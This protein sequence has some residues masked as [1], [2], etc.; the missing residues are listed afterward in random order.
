MAA[1]QEGVGLDRERAVRRE[2]AEDAGPEE[3]P[4]P[5]PMACIWPAHG[6]GFDEDGKGECAYNID[7]ERRGWKPSPCREA[8]IEPCPR[9]YAE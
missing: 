8:V 5:P 4:E 2:P 6:E 9:E 7:G 1:A 3:Q